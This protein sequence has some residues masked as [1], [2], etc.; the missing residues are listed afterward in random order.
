MAAI[1]VAMA[2]AGLEVTLAIP[3]APA[4]VEERRETGL[5]ASPGGGTHDS[6]SW[7]ELEVSGGDAARQKVERPP[8]GRR[9]KVVEIPCP[10]EVGTRVEPP[11]IPPL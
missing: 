6:P 4:A 11:A 8:M 10:G 3:P 9:V 2:E 5:P 7:S 1:L